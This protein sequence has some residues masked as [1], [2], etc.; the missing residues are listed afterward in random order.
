MP[1]RYLVGPTAADGN[2]ETVEGIRRDGHCRAFGFGDSVDLRVAATDSWDQ[3]FSREPAGWRPDFIALWLAGTSVPA[4]VWAAPV[5]L[6][7]VAASWDRHW[8]HYRR[9]LSRCDLVVTD[10]P[11]AAAFTRAGISHVNAV[12]LDGCFD[13][14]LSGPDSGAPLR[15]DIDILVLDDF[16][17]TTRREH[18][19][20]LARI[21]RLADRYHVVIRAGIYDEDRRTLL[22]RARL[23]VVS[24]DVEDSTRVA[25]EAVEAG[26]LVVCV[27][28]G[29]T[30][31]DRLL[32]E[33]DCLTCTDADREATIETHL[34]SEVDRA[35]KAAAVRSKAAR[36]TIPARWSEALRRIESDWPLLVDRS[37]CRLASPLQVGWLDR[38]W[39]WLDAKDR[40]GDPNL[41]TDLAAARAAGQLDGDG[42]YFLGLVAASPRE[43]AEAFAQ[44]AIR[45]PSNVLAQL[46]RAEALCANGQRDAAA[47]VVQAAVSALD[48][49]PA[50]PA[51]WMELPLYAPNTPLLRAEWAKAGW[52]NAGQ[53][54]GEVTAKRAIVRWRLNA[55]LADLTGQLS[56]FHE[57]AASRPDLPEARAALGCAL[58]RAGRV[59]ES[60]PHLRTAVEAQPFDLA[61][62]RAFGHVLGETGATE[63]RAR[64]AA[65]RRLLAKVAPGNVPT[66]PWFAA[67]RPSDTEPVLDGPLGVVWEGDVRGLHSL[68][69]VNRELCSALVNEGSVDVSVW[70]TPP[71]TAQVTRLPARPELRAALHRRQRAA[72]VHVRHQW[73]PRWD[74]PREGRWVLVQPWEYGSLPK[75][76]V[77]PIR[78][79]VDEVW[80][81]SRHV[82][83]TYLDAG[84][85]EDRV[86]VIPLGV[87]PTR[88]RPAVPPAKLP[89][90]G[91]VRFLFVG[92]TIWRKGIDLLLDAFA[93][94]FR[95]GEPVSLLIKGMGNDSFYRGKTADGLIAQYQARNLLIHVIDRDFSDDELPGLYAACDCLVLPY[96][97]EGFALPVVEAMACGRPVIVTNG[98]A[99]RDYCDDS[100][101][102]LVAARRA[103]VPPAW[104]AGLRCVG[105]PWVL[106]PDAD[107]L[108]AALRSVVDDPATARA[109]GAAAAE[110]IG[111]DWTWADA[112]HLV[113]ERVG[114][115]AARPTRRWTPQELP[116]DLGRP[117]KLISRP[118]SVEVEE[119]VISSRPPPSATRPRP[120]EKVFIIKQ[121]GEKRT[122]TNLL[123]YCLEQ[124]YSNVLVLV[125]VLGGKHSP[126]VNLAACWNA[127]SGR[128]N[129]ERAF[130]EIATYDRPAETTHKG[131]P[132]QA[133]FLDKWGTAIGQAFIEGQLRFAVSVKDP[134]A[135]VAS[136][137]RIERWPAPDDPSS[138][139]VACGRFNRRYREWLSLRNAYPGR[140][141]I[142][143]YEDLLTNLAPTMRDFA[144]WLGTSGTPAEW[145]L[146]GEAVVPTH[147]D[148]NAAWAA[149]GAA[150][151]PTYY[152]QRRYFDDLGRKAR[153]MIAAEIDWQI[154][155]EFSYTPD[156]GEQFADVPPRSRFQ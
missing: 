18:L 152:L 150:F 46:A 85:P 9:C 134:F 141:R 40:A 139:A 11:A 99:C 51:P 22:R 65:D 96:R 4:W 12:V 103:S 83:E 47:S 21:A 16:D 6:V 62:A 109:K 36:R 41:V 37:G 56:Y 132:G 48:S 24:E 138:I 80:V 143:R 98:G 110:R 17:L 115:L 100:T 45:R 13:D 82:R 71:P 122:G 55:L 44:A 124:N 54:A 57:A 90:E 43:A 33:E 49:N 131:D 147:W 108:R 61:A 86:H 112:A 73:P 25:A 88:F 130:V 39:Q 23:V 146:P 126:P 34:S 84:I 149:P 14:D 118:E 31:A 76:W 75:D 32:L 77:E 7:G 97:A 113:A 28:D 89:G 2:P 92:G 91:T 114:I 140:F 129:R 35:A 81:H 67:P 66:E 42:Y 119:S 153:E 104:A 60:I 69:L 127:A 72:A 128:S 87:D 135:W 117:A 15:R 93:R 102:F 123:Q 95:P 105:E 145:A 50:V 5:P 74:P 38:T 106:E 121:Y 133:A 137:R 68:A 70:P 107:E 63:E 19:R 125:H 1:L 144:N 26:A 10:P 111:R 20:R 58:A 101:A 120:G 79:A 52:S 30:H 8:H 53:P 27:V 78:R 59:A 142:V 3:V 29:A 154:F 151:D 148:D 64:L 136:I 116:Q 94:E 156:A 155:A